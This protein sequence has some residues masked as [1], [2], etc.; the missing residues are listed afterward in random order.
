MGAV[1]GILVG[2]VV[3]SLTGGNDLKALDAKLIVPALRRYLPRSSV[4]KLNN[5]SGYKLA[6]QREKLIVEKGPN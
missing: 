2:L 4:D 6:P 3:S 1:V 5:D